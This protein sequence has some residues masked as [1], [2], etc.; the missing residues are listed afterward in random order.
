MARFDI[1]LCMADD[2]SLTQ[3]GR[4][5]LRSLTR[6]QGKVLVLVCAG[7]TNKQIAERIGT[8]PQ[9]IKNCLREVMD[10]AGR[11]NRLSLVVFA[12]GTGAVT[13]PCTHRRNRAESSSAFA[14]D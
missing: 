4:L 13:C 12:F 7:L 11:H 9:V 2:A 1:V 14:A 6:W 5:F 3:A 8:S 10:K